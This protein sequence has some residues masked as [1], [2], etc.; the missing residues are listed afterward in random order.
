MKRLKYIVLL[1]LMVIT[2]TS[3]NKWLDLKPED[4][5]IRQNYWNTK[6]QLNA[7]VVG[8]YSSMLNNNLI[9]QLFRW[10]EMRGDMV[11][12]TIRASIDD[13]NIKDNNL[14]SS[15]TI[16]RWGEVY[17]TINY[18]NTV[19]Q[20]APSVKEKDNTL[21]EL[22]LNAYLAEAHALR[23]LMYFYLLR[24]FG[25]VPL[26]LEATSS[27][28]TLVQLEK[29]SKEDVYK[30]IIEDLSFA[31]Q[32]AVENYINFNDNKGRINKYS[33]YAILADVY[34][35]NDDY[36]NA[37]VYCDKVINSN[38]F[39]LN[40]PNNIQSFFTTVF[41]N[42]N[43]QESIFELQFD[44]QKQS[45]AFNLFAATV[46]PYI[47]SNKALDYFGLDEINPA[48]VDFR[49]DGNS[50]RSSDQSIT[51]HAGIY[52]GSDFN[53]VTST[54]STA[55]WFLYRY[56]D[57]L[58]LKAEALAWSSRGQEA[59]DLINVIRTRAK[60][61][62]TT[63]EVPAADSPEKISEY[64]LRERSREFAFEGKRWFDMLRIAKRNNYRQLDLLIEIVAESAPADRQQSIINKYKDTRSHYL[65]INEFELQRDKK[66]VQ[67]PFYK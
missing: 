30:Q 49:G 53:L 16:T 20:F 3:C 25:E 58:L 12:L 63:E 38:L 27:D 48:N 59:I 51:K 2:A 19:I 64:I 22:Q 37:I 43:S 1:F 65:P 26:Q 29:S 13:V 18:C 17:Q 42:G 57:I 7:S 35:W 32:N 66:L 47:I 6:E 24:S 15:N 50:L 8:C 60:A 5:I 31:Q 41:R 39:A 28:Q 62:A 55:N 44:L 52:S 33:V 10:G 9:S 21:T 4:G 45:P 23:G 36:E 54:T 56:S 14:L 11:A 61:L 34:L 46:R 67:N 40:I